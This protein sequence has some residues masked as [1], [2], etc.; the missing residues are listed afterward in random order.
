MGRSSYSFWL[1]P[2]EPLRTALTGLVRSLAAE[3]GGPEF[4]PHLT[5]YVGPS[6]PEEAR[7]SAELLAQAFEPAEIEAERLEQSAI[8]SKTFFMRFRESNRARL[9]FEMLRDH[10]VVPSTYAFNPHLSLLYKTMAESERKEL[11]LRS[12]ESFGIALGRWRFDRVCAVEFEEPWTEK[13]AR[14]YK[15]IADYKLARA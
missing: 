10:A 12:L 4:D 1:I 9:M 6:T 13:S 8:F 3:F 14:S 15:V 11:C 2:A 7:R 5:L